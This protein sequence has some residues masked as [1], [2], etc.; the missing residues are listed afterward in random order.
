M[1]IASWRPLLSFAP[2]EAKSPWPQAPRLHSAP[3]GVVCSSKAGDYKRI[4]SLRDGILLSET[5]SLFNLSDRSIACMVF[6]VGLLNLHA[7]NRTSLLQRF[8]SD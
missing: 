2:L 6:W 3:I 8:S 4:S 1:F 5:L 7:C